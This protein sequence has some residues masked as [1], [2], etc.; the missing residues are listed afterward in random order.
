MD[1][2]YGPESTCSMYSWKKYQSG[3]PLPHCHPKTNEYKERNFGYRIDDITLEWYV[4]IRDCMEYN[5]DDD[6]CQDCND[7]SG[8]F[9]NI[10][11]S[12]IR[13]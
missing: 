9:C 13:T 7:E 8:N 4:G 1:K 6:W 5:L 12:H 2:Y 11:R 10:N 3:Y